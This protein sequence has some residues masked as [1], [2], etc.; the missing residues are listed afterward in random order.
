MSTKLATK[1]SVPNSPSFF[2]PKQLHKTSTENRKPPHWWARGGRKYHT[3]VKKHIMARK[4]P[5]P[6]GG[7]PEV[8]SR[9]HHTEPLLHTNW[10]SLSG[11]HRAGTLA[12]LIFTLLH[13][14]LNIISMRTCE[15]CYYRAEWFGISFNNVSSQLRSEMTPKQISLRHCCRKQCSWD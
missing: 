10:A 13:N 7:T 15:Y 11:K 8:T 1:T 14:C 2:P 6:A 5:Q 4:S 12:V 3:I 9:T